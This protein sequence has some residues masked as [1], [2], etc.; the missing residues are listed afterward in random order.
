MSISF[1]PSTYL[2]TTEAEVTFES[3]F[4]ATSVEFK[5]H[6]IAADV[7]GYDAAD[8]GVTIRKS[9]SGVFIAECER[10]GIRVT[11]V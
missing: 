9:Q 7:L 5:F 11:R 3:N 4:D 8:C 1:L 10:R 2:P 6:G